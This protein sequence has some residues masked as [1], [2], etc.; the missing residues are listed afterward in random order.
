VN[1]IILLLQAFSAMDH[2]DFRNRDRGNGL[3]RPLLAKSLLVAGFA[4]ALESAFAGGLTGAAQVHPPFHGVVPSGSDV[5]FSTRFKRT[6]AMQVFTAYKGTRVEWVYTNDAAYVSDF[7][8]VTP[9]FGVTLNANPKL[10]TD[11]G[12]VRDFDGQPLAAP[13]MKGWGVLW[14]SSVHPDAQTAWTQQLQQ[15]MQLGASS[16]QF[17][18]PQ[19]QMYAANNQGGDFN[20]VMQQGFAAW[21]RSEA[22]PA[23]VKAAG[24]QDLGSGDSAYRDW[25]SSQHGVRDAADY[26]QRLRQLPSTPLWLAYTRHTV[27]QWHRQMRTQAAKLA[28]RPVP[29]SMNLGGLYEPLA[30]NAFFFLAPLADY[31][32]AETQIK[33]WPLQ[34]MQAAT[35]RALG[36]GFVPSI[37][38]LSLAENRTGIASLYALGGQVVVPWDVYD[39]N[40]AQ[41]KGK[42]FFGSPDDYADLYAFVRAHPALFDKLEATPL[43][44][45][46]VPVDKGLAGPLRSLAQRLVA[47]QVP[48]AFVPVGGDANY[49]PDPARL[50]HLTLLVTTNAD[51]DYP[52]GAL[53][54]LT[55]S[56]VPR[57]SSTALTAEKI[58]E[59]Q[60]FLA[61]PGA[62]NLRLL[63]RADPAK[64]ER[65]VV[66]VVDATRGEKNAA[67]PA[68]RRRIGLR[69]SLLDGATVSSAR[70]VQ[71]TGSTPV[72]PDTAS[73][74]H[75]F[76]GLPGCALWGVLDIQLAK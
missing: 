14:A 3:K 41:G 75:V 9:W 53:Q 51:A 27:L 20:P 60:P 48:F 59:L 31:S 76:F 21:L 10:A 8:A 70:W 40:D 5:V 73:R 45:V 17:D 69:S 2:E 64:P 57:L 58:A 36:M 66:H 26:R 16:V 61:A 50:R 32:M 35:A 43:V 52:P 4:I 6:E 49:R 67:D 25:L 11:A 30:S 71:P 22:A 63:P 18:D 39:G 74:S 15:A 46:V 28:G 44:G 1:Q 65:L 42:R 13:W 56:G 24:L 34:V 12:A 55:A 68:C 33:D 72:S 62:E 54:A 37:K 38:P 23:D 19:L 29:W 7:K 47:Q